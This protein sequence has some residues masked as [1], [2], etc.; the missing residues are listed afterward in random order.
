MIV[1]DVDVIDRSFPDYAEE[2]R[3]MEKEVN[4][5]S[6]RLREYEAQ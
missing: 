6:G 1:A 2:D 4:W 5:R 3:S